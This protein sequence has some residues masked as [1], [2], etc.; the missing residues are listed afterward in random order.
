MYE[1]L[2]YSSFTLAILTFFMCLLAYA[3]LGKI[4]KATEQLN[5]SEVAN[6]TGDLSTVKKSIQTLNNRI[7]G[8]HS[9]KVEEQAI[10]AQLL[11][12]QQ[13]PTQQPNGKL[14]G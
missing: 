10:L 7:N 9:P 5:W 8:L 14:S 2:L 13:A 1:I 6:I 3:H 11:Q 12:T 4:Q